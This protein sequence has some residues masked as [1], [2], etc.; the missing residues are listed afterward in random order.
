[1]EGLFVSNEFGSMVTDWMKVPIC[2]L[3]RWNIK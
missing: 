2:W 3:I 1:M